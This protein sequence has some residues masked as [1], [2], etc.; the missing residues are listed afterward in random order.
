MGAPL[1]PA[2]EFAI[3]GALLEREI[4]YEELERK[5]LTAIGGAIHKAIE[6]LT[7]NNGQWD[8]HGVLMHV[9]ASGVDRSRLEEYIANVAKHR[10][11]NAKDIHRLIQ[12]RSVL[13]QMANDINAQLVTGDVDVEK[14][15]AS[16]S[17]R[18]SKIRDLST[19]ES[20]LQE[21][22]P[23]APSGPAI[24]SLPKLS[25]ATNGV[26]GLW[27]IG[28]LPAIGKSTLAEQISID[29]GQVVPV[30]YYDFE[31][32]K[33][34]MLY[35][36]VQ[37]FGLD[38]VRKLG[39]QFYIR[40][41]IR[42]LTRDLGYVKPPAL[43]VIDSIQKIATKGDD[44]RVGLDAWI[45]RFE[46]LKQEGYCV[47]L[48]SEIPREKYT[49]EPRLDMF[50]ESGALE[51]AADTAVALTEKKPFVQAHVVKNR[52][53]P[54]TGPLTLLERRKPFWFSEVDVQMGMM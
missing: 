5:T 44:R 2:L 35:R 51:Y 22:A 14:L 34:I 15:L 12:D 38:K 47:I 39:R 7:V 36:L 19:V 43:I 13:L 1:A 41:S 20:D 52:H 30:L 6:T 17:V 42:T 9:E 25:S 49:G 21:G 4:G 50:K 26:F 24:K 29:L 10:T 53:Y 48:V 37:N 27:L 40:D 3:I 33:R 31:N 11:V 8:R 18:A 46:E 23:E 16:A 54:K 32:G 28:G 45:H